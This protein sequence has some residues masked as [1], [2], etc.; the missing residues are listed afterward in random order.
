MVKGES[1]VE[2]EKRRREIR[3]GRVVGIVEGLII[4]HFLL[5]LSSR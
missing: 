3:P 2:L 5:F 4:T 1:S